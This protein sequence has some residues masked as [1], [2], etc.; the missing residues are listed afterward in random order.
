MLSSFPDRLSDYAADA[1]R[2]LGVEVRLGE[3]VR[4]IDKEGLRLGKPASRRQTFF[5]AREL[6]PDLPRDGLGRRLLAM[7]P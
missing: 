7:A 5:G 6:R 3:A 1:L 2:S 4:E